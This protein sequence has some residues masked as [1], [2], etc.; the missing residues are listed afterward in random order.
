MFEIYRIILFQTGHEFFHFRNIHILVKANKNVIKVS[1][2]R[3]YGSFIYIAHMAVII[4]GNPFPEFQVFLRNKGDFIRD[5]KHRL[6][7][8]VGFCILTDSPDDTGM[9]T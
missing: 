4:K 7:R 9:Y 8:A 6:Q 5:A 2:M 1:E 3:R